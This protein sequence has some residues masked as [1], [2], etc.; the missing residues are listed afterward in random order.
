MTEDLDTGV[1][2]ILDKIA[3]LGIE[4]STYVFYTSDNGAIALLGDD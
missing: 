3:E 4:D 1:G 2:M